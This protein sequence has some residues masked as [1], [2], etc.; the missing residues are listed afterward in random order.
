MQW[1]ITVSIKPKA[2]RKWQLNYSSVEN[3]NSND[4][5]DVEN[6]NK[7]YDNDDDDDDDEC[8]IDGGRILS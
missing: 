3:Y 4:D 6:D 1:K 2:P 7:N 8:C 5:D